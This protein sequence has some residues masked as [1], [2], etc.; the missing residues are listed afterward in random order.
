MNSLRKPITYSWVTFC[1]T[2]LLTGL[3]IFFTFFSPSP[4][5]EA[6]AISFGG[7]GPLSF[8]LEV[9]GA[10]PSFSLSS[11]RGQRSYAS[12]LASI[13][14]FP[15]RFSPWS[16]LFVASIGSSIAKSLTGR[17]MHLI[18]KFFKVS[19]VPRYWHSIL[20]AFGSSCTFARERV[21]IRLL[22]LIEVI[23]FRG[24]DC[25]ILTPSNL[26][27][28]NSEGDFLVRIQSSQA[29][30]FSPN[31]LSLPLRNIQLNQGIFSLMLLRT[32]DSPQSL[33]FVSS[34]RIEFRLGIRG[35]ELASAYICSIVSATFCIFKV[36]IL[37]ISRSRIGCAK[38]CCR[39][40][41]FAN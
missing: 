1:R 25:S 9:L 32:I 10:K 4:D 33:T 2:R 16:D 21:W 6:L 37:L 31:R 38:L 7:G 30:D 3:V 14:V 39:D 28:C 19:L 40:I 23:S 8:F 26:R 17:F 29:M 36:S 12:Q 15:D 34:K 13:R 5:S 20:N 18:F 22:Y 27:V 35:I 11:S 41:C 24:Y